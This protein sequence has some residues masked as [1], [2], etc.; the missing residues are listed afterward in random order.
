MQKKKTRWQIQIIFTQESIP[1]TNFRELVTPFACTV[2]TV[3]A[4]CQGL[5]KVNN[6]NSR[7]TCEI[8]SNLTIKTPEQHQGRRSGVSV[9]KFEQ[10]SYLFLVFLLLALKK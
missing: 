9:V 2:I 10:I 5:F 3:H 7:K 6:R 1:C 8:C 4:I